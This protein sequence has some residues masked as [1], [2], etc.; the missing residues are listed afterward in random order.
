MY[1]SLECSTNPYEAVINDKR[2]LMTSGIYS[3]NY[4]FTGQN[5]QDIMRQ[6]TPTPS[7]I[8]CMSYSLQW[9]TLFPTNPNTCRMM[10]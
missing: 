4:S 7:I 2:V 10:I 9:G 1:T 8:D 6:V 3:C 5:I